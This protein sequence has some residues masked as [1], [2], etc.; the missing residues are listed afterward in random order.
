MTNAAAD[1]DMTSYFPEFGGAAY[2]SFREDLSTAVEGLCESLPGL[3]PVA[4]PHLEGW[5]SWLLR[6]EGVVAQNR[7]LGSYLGCL[8]AAD[9][10]NE[11]IQRDVA[12]SAQLRAEIE[13]ALIGLR[14]A[15]RDAED[16]NFARLLAREPLVPVRHYL[17]QA[18]RRSLE[19]MD[20]ISEG[21]AADLGVNGIG[22]WGRLY[23][24]ISGSLMFTFAMPG[25]EPERLPV[26][27]ARSLMGDV[28]PV[29]RRAA[30]RGA[31]E[32][33]EEQAEVCAASLNAIAG[34][35]LT[36]YERRG[37]PH[38][39]DPA[40]LDSGI[41]R[42]TLEVMIGVARERAEVGRKIL[43][44]RARRMGL[45]TLAFSDLEA[46]LAASSA[47][48][49]SYTEAAG[50]VEEAFTRF[51][52]AMGA[53]AAEAVEK[54]WIDHTPRAGKRPGGFCSS[55]PL[56]QESRIFMTFDGALGD[57]STLAHELGHA[58]HSRVMGDLRPWARGYPMTLA[59]TASTFAEQVLVDRILSDP[60]S[61]A[62][63]RTQVL[64]GRLSDA[65]AFLLNTTM[66][67]TFEKAFYEERAAGEVSANRL[68]AL[69]R[70]H[71]ADWYGDTIDP[72]GLDPYFWA[73]K[74]HF[75]ISGL[76]FYNFPYTFGYLFSQGIFARAQHEGAEFLPRYEALL[77]DTGSA[78]AEEVAQR[79][80][81]VDLEAPEFWNE[82]IDRVA[83]DFEIYANSAF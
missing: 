20:A 64:D 38:F 34:T 75:Y 45:P 59:E 48:R 8:S 49:I 9:A 37:I 35:R 71:Q 58:W 46:P 63:E 27:R 73:S 81:G 21:L 17:K 3:G 43:R 47:R 74:L 62:E 44:E 51:Y 33:W 57:V 68:C 39:L 79:H 54:K 19:S 12:W 72:E 70:E 55:S 36:L 65:T 16:A 32:A 80:L 40:C 60:Q 14:A 50:R 30:F 5:E 78:T 26:S 53:F 31:N 28:D 4:L 83:E 82:S 1:W 76:S 66:R 10:H 29:C 18:R 61:S 22:A 41:S 77:C 15:L 13:K 69:M 23:D 67:F 25:Q 56:L 11:E 24:Q 7:H 6:L 42:K 2:R 52:P